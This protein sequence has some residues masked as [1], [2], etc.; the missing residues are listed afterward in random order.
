MSQLCETCQNYAGGCSWTEVD[1]ATGRVKFIPVPGWKAEPTVKFGKYKNFETF[2][3][4]ECP[5]YIKDPPRKNH[6]T[7]KRAY[8]LDRIEV[9][10]MLENGYTP[11]EIADV[12]DCSEQ[13]ICAIRRELRGAG[14]L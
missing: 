9:L 4:I 8:G 7:Q 6:E 14:L 5:K 12:F 13:T 11:S 10:N 1:E 2:K 3:I